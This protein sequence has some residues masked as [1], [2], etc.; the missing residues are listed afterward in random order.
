[1]ISKI[2]MVIKVIILLL[3]FLLTGLAYAKPSRIVVVGEAAYAPMEFIGEK[4]TPLGIYV[5]IWG[6]WSKKTG[7]PVD[8]RCMNWADALA[9]VAE[10]EAD[11]V[12]GLG[13]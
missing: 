6:L 9:M 13:F 12:G 1:M 7:I 2:F 11:V 10:G 3:A 5:D 4:S 8:Y